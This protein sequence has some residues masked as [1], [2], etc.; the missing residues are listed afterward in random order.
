MRRPVMV[1]ALAVLISGAARP[2][3]GSDASGTWPMAGHNLRNTRHQVAESII[4]PGNVGTLGP[5]WV[6]TTGGD[7]SATPA[8][9]NTL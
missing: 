4:G 5:K 3:A 9:G 7:V 2:P 6:F 8:V 1:L